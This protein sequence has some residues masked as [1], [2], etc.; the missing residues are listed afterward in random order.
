MSPRQT[1]TG[2][3][4]FDASTRAWVSEAE[5]V[6]TV[7]AVP[8]IDG[9]LQLD[10]ATRRQNSRD[11]GRYVDRIPQAVLRSGSVADVQTMVRFCRRHQIPLAARGLAN[12]THGQGLVDGLLIENRSL[13]EIHSIQPDSA[14]VG[15]GVT[16]L[17]LTRAAYERGLTPPALTGYLSLTIGGTLSLG[18]VPPAFRAGS[19][20]DS[21]RE[22]EV[23]TG[24]GDVVRC[25]ESRHRDLFE[26]VL[27]GVGQ[28]GIITRA[29]VGLVPAKEKVRGHAVSY[30]DIATFFEDLR[31]LIRRGEVSEIYGDWWRPGETGD[32]HHLNAF[33]FYNPHSPPDDARVL[34]GLTVSPDEAE[35][36]DDDF[37]AHVER[38]DVAVDQLREAIGWDDLIKPW[39]TVWLPESQAERFVS[40]VV[41]QLTPDDIG[42]GGFVL[43]YVHQRSRLLRPSLRLPG[44]DGSEWVYLFTL[45]TAAPGD[46][47]PERASELLSRNRRLYERA[48]ALGG[49]RYPIESVDFTV[50]DW[51]DHYGDRWP[52]LAALKQQ[53]DPDG[54]LTP[55]AGV[56]GNGTARGNLEPFSNGV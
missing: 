34:R 48:R 4:G 24:A 35:V 26:A 22:L 17:E 21:V 5:A 9:T 3:V 15:A 29:T 18:G 36:T 25:S 47:G 46:S 16:W 8:P 54:I 39:F 56:F 14:Q 27:A 12:T 20:V 23:V 32:V 52:H 2:T 1:E 42:N 37:L 33:T 38:I 51:K 50:A 55:G 7:D 44:R 43:M 53:F 40:E 28:Y 41:P 13:A 45:M 31:T 49:V 10:P 6:G 11:A 19:Q 30:A